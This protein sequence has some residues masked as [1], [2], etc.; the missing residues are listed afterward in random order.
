MS[1]RR[2]TSMI[3]L[4][5]LA[6]ATALPSE[7]P[8][9]QSPV[10]DSAAAPTGE[11]TLRRADLRVAK[12]AYRL[13]LGGP[14]LC[15]AA[16][17]VTGLLLHHLPEYLPPDRALMIQRYRLDRGPGVL[18]VLADSPAARAG[19]VAGDVLLSVNGVAFPTPAVIARENRRKKW[20]AAVEA[21]EGQLEAELRLGPAELLLLREGRELKTRIEPITGCIGRV[22]LAR[23]TQTNAFANNG[24]VVMTTSML[25]FLRSDDE[26]AV[27]MGHELAHNLLRHPD[28]RDEEG[29]LAALGI[30]GPSAMWKREE[31]A[32]RLGLRLAAA[33]GYDLDAAIPFWR[34]YLKKYDWF[35]QIFRSHPSLGAREKIARDEIE[36]IRREAASGAATPS[37]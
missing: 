19:L 26:L 27:V 25:N 28:T 36:A 29:V 15:T 23:S 9:A 8:A 24:Y 31:A 4:A 10:R 5:W 17:P 37:S 11:S 6:M 14:P 12:V 13:A 7:A 21:T 20:R 3:V 1:R 33:A 22:R 34:R 18:S 35:P 16:W 2:S 30:S 32:D